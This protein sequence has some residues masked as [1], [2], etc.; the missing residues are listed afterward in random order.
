VT[1]NEPLFV[2]QFRFEGKDFANAGSV[3]TE[4][5]A[6]LRSLGLPAPLVRRASIVSYE[7]EMN[8]VIYA[9]SC[10]ATLLVDLRRIVL[11]FDDRGPGIPDIGLAMQVGYS[12]ATQEIREMGFGA[13]MGLP[14][15]QRNSDSL[16]VRSTV[17]HGTR[18]E[19]VILIPPEQAS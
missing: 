16:D 5:K 1:S 6:I 13:G 11:T 7:A 15:I 8:V 3:S 18:L 14:N 17:G 19:A 2:R 9:S 12:T 4:V 10:T